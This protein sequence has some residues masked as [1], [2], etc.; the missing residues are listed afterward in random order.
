MSESLTQRPTFSGAAKKT[1]QKIAIEEAIST[2]VFNA[3]ATLPPVNSTAELPYVDTKYVADVKDRLTNVEARVKA[4]DE[5]G[6]VLTV[7]SLTMPGI[8]GI[9]DTAVAVDTA[10]KVNNE[11]H[12]LY[13]A[14]PYADRFRAFGC[15]AMQDP[16]S[17]AAEAER[18]IKGLGFVGILINGFSN[19]GS[20]DQ[21]QY[22]DEPQCAPFWAKMAELDVPLYMHPRIPSPSQMR[23]YKGYEFLGGSP[24]G[25]GTETATHAIRLMIS[26]LFDKHPNLRI[27]LGHC[28]EGIPFS[29]NRIDHRLRHFQSHH[30]PCKLR[31]QEYWEKNF[32]ITTAGVIDDGT[33][34][35][36]L[37]SCGEDRLMWSVDYPYED[38]NE[39]GSWFDNLDLNNNSRAKIGWGNARR[40][41]KLD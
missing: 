11:I 3:T 2:H 8:E 34:F 18:C 26:G 41:L 35:N 24:W 27:I 16:K 7:V 32:Y 4:M 12:E 39:I 30:T 28:G 21:I 17:A 13:T 9:F 31:L 22:L 10:R 15:V 29:I 38:Y 40:I 36:T 1:F 14:G 33:F 25:F 5:A 37:K 20:A 19:I 6:V 23:A